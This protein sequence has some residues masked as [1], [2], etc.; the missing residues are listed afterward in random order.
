MAAPLY[1]SGVNGKEKAPTME[2]FAP[3]TYEP[4]PQ[5]A[6]PVQVMVPVA[7]VPREDAPVQ[8][9]R[10]PIEGAELVPMPRYEK[11]P[12]ALLYESGKEAESEVEEILLLKRD[13]SV[14]ARYPLVVALACEKY[15]EI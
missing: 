2:R 6:V 4:E 7:T 14:E 10:L 13:Q 12:L 8:Y 15:W 11:A 5:E 3:T 1:V 9:A